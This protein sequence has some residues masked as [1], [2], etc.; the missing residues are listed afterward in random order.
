M[1]PGELRYDPETHEYYMGL[2]RVASV[3]EVLDCAGLIS[4]FCKDSISADFGTMFHLVMTF[5]LFGKLG[6]VDQKFIDEGWMEAIDKFFAEQCP[7]PY[8]SPLRGV[9]R[10][11]FSQRHRF[12][13]ELDFIGTIKKYANKLCLSDWKSI[14]SADKHALRNC[15]LQ[16]CGY[17][18]LFR[19]YEQYRGRIIRTMTHFFPGGYQIYELK[20]PAAQTTFLSAVNLKK[21]KDSK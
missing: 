10:R 20:D 6:T 8:I 13:G 7:I 16:T 19:E 3:T 18:L 9:S 2:V 15:D 5:K 4:P 21:W 12:A 1:I 14:A 17:E 11:L